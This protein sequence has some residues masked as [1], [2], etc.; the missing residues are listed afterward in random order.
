MPHCS[1]FDRRMWVFLLTGLLAAPA[2]AQWSGSVHYGTQTIDRV[3]KSD[4]NWWSE[5]DDR[6]DVVS[7]GLGYRLA[8]GWRLL[9]DYHRSSGFT[10]S[11]R[12]PDGQA[13][14]LILI[15]ERGQMDTLSLAVS[16]EWALNDQWWLN[17]R[18]GWMHWR[19][20]VSGILPGERGND[21]YLGAGIARSVGGAYRLA[22]ELEAS[23]LQHRS[24]RL[25]VSRSFGN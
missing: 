14:T 21:P 4:G 11:N 2:S 9:G 5:V 18:L 20:D 6:T 15:L 25:G 13:C 24:L 8:P 3:V 7:L 16:R 12:C 17:A 1:L 23:E 19:M 22:L 10:V